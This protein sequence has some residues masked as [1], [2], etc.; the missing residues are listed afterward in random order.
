[1]GQWHTRANTERRMALLVAFSLRSQIYGDIDCF[2]L[3][4]PLTRAAHFQLLANISAFVS[5][6][7]SMP[8]AAAGLVPRPHFRTHAFLSR[9]TIEDNGFDDDTHH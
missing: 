3:F 5:E 6:I 9:C 1:M 8:Q 7:S 4:C 2:I